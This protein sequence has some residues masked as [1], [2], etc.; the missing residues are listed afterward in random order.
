MA[1]SEMAC[2][3]EARV[4]T[5]PD[6]ACVR[7]SDAL[8]ATRVW[9]TEA[10]KDVPPRPDARVPETDAPATAAQRSMP[11]DVAIG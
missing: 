11:V 2:S 7:L 10:R 1:R 3:M 8:P 6:R 4:M 9:A 5:A